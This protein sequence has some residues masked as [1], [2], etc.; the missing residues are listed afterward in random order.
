MY[1]N[2]DLFMEH[3]PEFIANHWLLSSLFM[4]LIFAWFLLERV[5]AVST[6]TAQE[7]T[8]QVN[9]ADAVV[10]DLRPSADFSRGHIAQS[11]NVP[12]NELTQ[13]LTSLQKYTGHPLILVCNTGVTAGPAGLMLRNAGFT[14]VTRLEGGITRWKQDGLPL[15]T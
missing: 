15:V 6:I 9:H 11:I 5:R 3:L 4:V 12:Y 13:G 2:H 8:Q 10:L 1:V 7:L 14:Q